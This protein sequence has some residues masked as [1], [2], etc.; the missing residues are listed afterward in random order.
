MSV[1]YVIHAVL[2]ALDPWKLWADQMHECLE[3]TGGEAGVTR[4][5]VG[6]QPVSKP[7]PY[8]VHDTIRLLSAYRKIYRL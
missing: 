8:S 3:E 2:L 6:A 1:Q 4:I 7:V 5:V